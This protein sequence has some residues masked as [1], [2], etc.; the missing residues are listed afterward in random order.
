MNNI[1]RISIPY[2]FAL[3]CFTDMLPTDQAEVLWKQVS[4][5]D[6]PNEL[7]LRG[8]SSAAPS[9]SASA[10]TGEIPNASE[11]NKARP[12]KDIDGP[13]VFSLFGW[14]EPDPSNPAKPDYWKA[15]VAAHRPL[16]LKSARGP[17]VPGG[18]PPTSHSAMKECGRD[19]ECSS[20][21]LAGSSRETDPMTW[22]RLIILEFELEHDE[23]NPIYGYG[24]TEPGTDGS[25]TSL[26]SGGSQ[27][28][29]GDSSGSGQPSG[30][31]QS[32]GNTTTPTGIPASD[33][34]SPSIDNL[35]PPTP[36]TNAA[37]HALEERTAAES[38]G[39]QFHVAF[40]PTELEQEAM[41]PGQESP[42][43]TTPDESGVGASQ[44]SSHHLD[45][46]GNWY[47]SIDDIHDSTV[48]RSRP[49]KALERM[50]MLAR[51]FGARASPP[52]RRLTMGE[53]GSSSRG[54][55]SG[56]RAGGSASPANAPGTSSPSAG[57]Q[58]QSQSRSSRHRAPHPGPLLPGSSGVGTMDVFAVLAE[59]IQQLSIPT[60]LETFLTTTVGVIKDI[61]QFHRVLIYQFDDAWNGQVGI[62]SL[63]SANRLH[64]AI[65]VVAELVDWSASHDLFKGMHFPATDIPPQ[66][67][68]ERR[69]TSPPLTKYHL[70]GS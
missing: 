31:T 46:D 24:E 9:S 59:V 16:T 3:E 55:G 47:P 4:F 35:P 64:F 65:Q 63:P 15:W 26:R 7:A 6:D 67:S 13:D 57:S 53:R 44:T 48:S 42:D 23:L 10:A 33:D 61:T 32:S 52:F 62:S 28:H 22:Q 14:T 2:L 66:V 60:D 36:L 12:T 30:S 38:S 20:E 51:G 68:P 5:L 11:Q 54:S 50:R 43:I 1:L 58:S 8:S 21:L 17:S 45:G 29:R 19:S 34:P 40:P 18:E 70:P 27:L 56:R 49:I 69:L 37:L 41:E 25:R 39:R